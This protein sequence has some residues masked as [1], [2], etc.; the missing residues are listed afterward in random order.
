MAHSHATKNTEK[1]LKA[2]V[3]LLSTYPIRYIADYFWGCSRKAGIDRYGIKIVESE[4][5]HVL[6]MEL[7][8][9]NIFTMRKYEPKSEKNIIFQIQPM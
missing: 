5:F 7:R 9:R 4:R 8:L 1:S 3:F 2:L 6:K